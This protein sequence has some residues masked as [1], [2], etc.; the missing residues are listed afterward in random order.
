M[1]PLPRCAGEEGVGSTMSA[2][3]LASAPAATEARP[4]VH[5]KAGAHRRGMLGHPWIYS[6]EVAMDA[7]AKALPPGTIVR[8]VADDG[9]AI[10]AAMF[11]PRPLISARF[12]SPDPDAT[13]DSAF[14]AERLRRATELRER[15]YGVSC[16]RL[17][18][19]EAD[20]MPGTIIDRY[21]DVVVAQINT[22]GIDRLAGELTAALEEVLRPRAILLR[23]EGAARALEGLEAD[24]RLVKGSLE[25]PV[26]LIENGTRFLADLAGG[27][28]TGWFYDQRENRAAVAALA[29]DARVLDLYSY[30]GGFAVQCA[31][32]GAAEVTAVD[33]SQPALDLAASAAAL[34]GVSSRVQFRREEAFALLQSLGDAGERFGIIIADPPAFVKS[35]KDLHQGARAY[36]KLARLA[37]GRVA[38]GG[39]LL[40]CSCSHH[41]ERALFAEQVWRGVHDAGRQGRILRFAGAA[42]DHPVHPALPETAYLKA[43]LLQLD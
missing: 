35:K 31:V 28:K 38:A 29:K 7:A 43:E 15:L 32:A 22:A 6:N 12:L 27:Q 10:G 33:R 25:G 42:A 23:S 11:N 5:L 21:G 41:V 9:R 13:I 20:G 19:A 16:Y 2:A 40:I 4:T 36:R 34:N 30:T 24:E 8:V 18:H 14:F 1:V 3:K 37:A 26:E 17:I 39:F